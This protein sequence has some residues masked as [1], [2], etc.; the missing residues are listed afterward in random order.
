MCFSASASLSASALLAGIGV[1]TVRKAQKSWELPYAAIPFLFALQQGTEGLLWLGFGWGADS[2][3]FFLTQLYSFFSHVLWP[4][5]VP[6]AVWLLEPSGPR[7]SALGVVGAAG[8]LVGSYLLYTLFAYPL[9]AH[10]VGGHIEYDSPHFYIAIVMTLYL[11]ATILSL[12]LSSHGAVKCFGALALISAA[13]A[14]FFYQRWYISVWCFFA[15]LVSVTVYLYF[16]L[17]RR[18]GRVLAFAN[19]GGTESI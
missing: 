11:T 17:P 2:L 18:P 16:A 15:A 4:V 6:L 9:H 10:P 5:Y 12:I 19:L 8:I 1:M 14:Y 3:N 7:R 13:A